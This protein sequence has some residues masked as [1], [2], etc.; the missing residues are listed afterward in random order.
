MGGATRAAL[1]SIFLLWAHSALAVAALRNLP[2][3][4]VRKYGVYWTGIHIAD[5]TVTQSALEMR[6]R[7][8]SYGV[9]KKVSKFKSQ[10]RSVYKKSDDGTL[11]PVSFNTV[12]RN[13]SRERSIDIFYDPN[14]GVTQESV[15]PPDN[16][17]KRPAV[18]NDLK[19]GALDPLT[20]ALW[21][22]MRVIEARK[23]GERSFSFPIYDGRR[24]SR[25]D[26][27]LGKKSEIS[28][29]GRSYNV[30][31]LVMRR[32]ALQGYTKRELERIKDEEPVMTIYV[33]DDEAAM[34]VKAEAAA[35]LGTAI[36]EYEGD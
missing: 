20:A 23:N 18:A 27:S 24:L 25:L 36:I 15:V 2:P 29:N 11:I 33:T 13:R 30:I 32:V 21:A 3:E 12:F 34:P 17:K 1:C 8:D 22:R 14:G 6:A 16:R 26:F 31:S 4:G 9:V 35:P 19:I 28:V 5:L 10:T 7:I